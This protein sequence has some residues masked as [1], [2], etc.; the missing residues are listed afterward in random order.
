[1]KTVLGYTD[2][3]VVAPGES[4]DVK[5]S[6]EDDSP[7]FDVSLLRLYCT[8]DDPRGPGIEAEPVDS[9]PTMTCPARCQPI[10]IGSNVVVPLPANL[11]IE[12]SFCLRVDLWP[13]LPQKGRQVPSSARGERTSALEFFS[14]STRQAVQVCVL[15][16][17]V[18]TRS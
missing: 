12:G 18:S 5:V 3:M 4:I 8:D 16:P 11:A 13:T 6:V 2:K 9:V 15:A 14:K 7:T 17:I 10:S 1:M